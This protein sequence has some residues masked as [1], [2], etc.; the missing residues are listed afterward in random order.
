[1]VDIVKIVQLNKLPAD[2]I[3]LLVL[4][5]TRWNQVVQWL[6]RIGADTDGV[7]MFEVIGHGSHERH[8]D[9]VGV[10]GPSRRRVADVD[11]GHPND[12]PALNVRGGA[13]SNEG[14]PV[15]GH[16]GYVSQYPAVEPGSL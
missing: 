10:R 3:R 11:L 6:L 5:R 7:T 1:M 15:G 13:A 8:I 16:R 12:P 14:R 2:R 9:S 4:R